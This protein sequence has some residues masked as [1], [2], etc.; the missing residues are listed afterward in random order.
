MK[1]LVLAL[2]AVC[3]VA[4]AAPITLY[5]VPNTWKLESYNEKGV[6]LWHTQATCPSGLMGLPTA[7]TVADHNRLYSTVMAAKLS[8]SKMFVMYE[9]VNSV[10]TIISYGLYEL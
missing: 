5:V 6:T 7:A 4:A 1:K 3:N 8:N 9:N 10:C 2:L